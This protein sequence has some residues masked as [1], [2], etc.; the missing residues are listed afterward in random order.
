MLDFDISELELEF[1][2]T[3]SVS[4]PSAGHIIGLQ[5]QPQYCSFLLSFWY[6]PEDMRTIVRMLPKSVNI[7]DSSGLMHAAEERC[8]S[9]DLALKEM[10][11]ISCNS[12]VLRHVC[13]RAV[14][15][16]HTS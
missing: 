6:D 2:C 4:V 11:D 16:F 3:A 10:Q 8:R 14:A 12:L 13:R 9:V 1:Q 5:I 7:M 15:L